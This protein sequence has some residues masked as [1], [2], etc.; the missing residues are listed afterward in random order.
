MT[1]KHYENKDLSFLEFQI[2]KEHFAAD[3][4]EVIEVLRGTELTAVPKTEDYI[5]GIISF[6][7]EIV[8]VVNASLK[9]NLRQE[10]LSPGKIIIVFDLPFQDEQVRVGMLV[11]K[12]KKVITL[13][14]TQIQPVPE[15]GCYFNPEFLRGAIAS[16]AGFVMIIDAPKIFSTREV[17][18]IRQLNE[19]K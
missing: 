13:P 5:E 6:R 12:V 17:E 16:P 15:F 3:V 14:E 8:S 19:S 4:S 1:R 10:N 18:L 7:G 9:M 2:G 11:D